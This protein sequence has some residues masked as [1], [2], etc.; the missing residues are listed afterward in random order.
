MQ[1]WKFPIYNGT[2]ETLKP[3][4]DKK[5]GRYRRYPDSKTVNFHKFLHCLLKARHAQNSLCKNTTNKKT[6]KNIKQSYFR[7][8][9]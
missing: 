2:L 3:K 9:L 1:R 6:V 8:S 7:Q 4:S 5:C